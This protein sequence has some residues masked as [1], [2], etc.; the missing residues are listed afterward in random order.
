MQRGES[1]DVDKLKEL[2][3]DQGLSQ[4]ELSERAGIS[5][6]SVWKIERGGGANPATLK[7]IADVL[8]VRASELVK[9]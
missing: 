2:R 6:T 9:R 5:N 4:R 3:I 7:K 8:G 1:V